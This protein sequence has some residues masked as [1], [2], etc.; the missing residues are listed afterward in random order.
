MEIDKFTIII[1]V[2]I[3]LYLYFKQN[4]LYDEND[5]IVKD[6]YEKKYKQLKEELN[7]KIMLLN[8]ILTKQNELEKKYD[9]ITNKSNETIVIN[10]NNTQIDPVALRDNRVLNDPLYP[11]INRTD[12]PTYDQL[13]LYLSNRT[14]ATRGNSDTFRQVG[15]TVANDDKRTKYL[16]MGRSIH[17]R[18]DGEFYL[19]EVNSNNM[20]KIP[21]VDKSNRQLIKDIYNIPETLDINYGVLAGTTLT[22]QEIKTADLSTSWPNYI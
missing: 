9:T 4:K 1:L 19:V 15:I 18:P 20:M 17:G 21:L 16:L 7:N 8:S 10:P 14:I 11:V 3:V 6:E 5:I 13:A 12:R 2:V 22:I